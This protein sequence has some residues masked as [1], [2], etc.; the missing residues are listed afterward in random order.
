MQPLKESR[1][2]TLPNCKIVYFLDLFVSGIWRLLMEGVVE[3]EKKIREDRRK[4]LAI[5]LRG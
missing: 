4:Q 1:Q 5:E 2:A 3:A